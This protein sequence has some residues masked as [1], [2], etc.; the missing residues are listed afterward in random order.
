[1]TEKQSLNC[2]TLLSQGGVLAWGIKLCHYVPNPS[3]INTTASGHNILL[4]DYRSQ[5]GRN[6]KD[7]DQTVLPSS[8]SISPFR[9]SM[10]NRICVTFV[11]HGDAGTLDSQF[12][13]STERST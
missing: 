1:L 8:R 4:I 10:V 5:I 2:G 9:S 11:W 3:G 6:R 13:I 12:L 7:G